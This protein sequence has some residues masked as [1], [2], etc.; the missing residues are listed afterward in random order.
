LSS[1]VVVQGLRIQEREDEFKALRERCWQSL[2]PVG[3]VE[4]MLVD[5]IVTAQWRLRR[6]LMAETGEIVL[7]VDGGLRRRADR[8]PLAAG[9]IH[10]P[11]HDA[12]VQMEKS[13]QGLDYLKAVL[14]SVREDVEREGELTQAVYDQ[15][16]E[17][18][19]NTPNHLTRQLLGYRERCVRRQGLTDSSVEFP[20]TDSGGLK[21]ST[22]NGRCCDIIEGK[23][24][25]Y[26][27]LS[28]QSEEREDKEETAHGSW[29]I[30]CRRRRCWRRFCG[31]R[32]R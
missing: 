2:A 27:E 24:V 22:I 29:R 15:L 3:P 14:G 6:A 18:F 8:A 19:I 4:E 26:E 16:L 1:E 11:L 30:Y 10:E 25:E 31:M 28:G 5:K 20:K 7:S 9:D 32:T 13:T 21:V 17:R 12:A 23:L